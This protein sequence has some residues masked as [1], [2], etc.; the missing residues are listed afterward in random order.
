MKTHMTRSLVP[1]LSVLA[2]ALCAMAGCSDTPDN[3]KPEARTAYVASVR[4]ATGDQR[5]YIGTVRA[6]QRGQLSFPV[7]GKV[8]AVLVEPGDTVK[9]GQ[10]L[11]RLDSV[12]FAAQ[13]ASAAGDVARA[14]AALDEVQRRVERLNIAEKADALSPAEMTA[15]KAELAAALAAVRNARAQ[16]ELAGW[17]QG[18][19]TLRATF[20]GVVAARNIEVG[21]SVGQGAVAIQIDGAG[22]ELSVAIPG[23]SPLS[24]GQAVNLISGSDTVASKVLRV[25]GRVDAGGVRTAYIAVPEA[26]TVGSTWSVKIT[27]ST[28]GPARLQVPFRAVLPSA[29]SGKGQVLRLAK[30]GKTTELAEVSLG[31]YHGDW[32]EVSGQ[33][34]AGQ[35]VVVAGAK[36]IRPGTQIKPV[37]M[38]LGSEQ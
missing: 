36:A 34:S 30:D 11:A 37:E 28:E 10:V 20:D 26:A 35:R 21:Q 19:A 14:Q 12:P 8:S 1:R 16:H 18:E 23:A 7:S 24:V 25:D 5:A 17:S 22:R 27:E 6:T 4:Q 9:K 33:I 15:A 2:I 3:G 38:K 29:V 31:Q 13:E 32:I